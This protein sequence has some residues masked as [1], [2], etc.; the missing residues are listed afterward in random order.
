MRLVCSN[1]VFGFRQTMFFIEDKKFYLQFISPEN[2]V[3]EVLWITCVFFDN[4]HTGRN[5]LF[6]EQWFPPGYPSM[7]I[8]LVQCFSDS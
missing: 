6:R 4:L 3:Q 1:A 5:V 2:I 7:N 8:I